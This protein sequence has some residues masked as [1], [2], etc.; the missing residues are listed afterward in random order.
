MSEMQTTDSTYRTLYFLVRH[1]D[2]VAIVIGLAPLLAGLWA[3]AA[4]LSIAFAIGGVFAATF[5]YLIMR[6]YVELVRV[7]VDMLL[8]K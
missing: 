2:L 4:G 6:S 7:I 8:P 3:Y 5:L 1:G